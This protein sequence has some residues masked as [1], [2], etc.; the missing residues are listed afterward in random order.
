MWFVSALEKSSGIRSILGLHENVCTG[1]SDGYARMS[2]K[3]ALNLLHLGPGLAN[4][5]A[6][7]HNARRAR[8]PVVNVIGSMSS[9]HEGADPPLNMDIAALAGTVS[10]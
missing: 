10:R 3:P 7:L 1:A 9:W 6:N 4:G 5:L 2:G 8:S